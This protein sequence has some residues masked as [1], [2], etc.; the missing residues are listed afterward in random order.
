MRGFFGLV[1]LPAPGLGCGS[2]SFGFAALG[3]GGG[4][5]VIPVISDGTV[6]RVAAAS[7]TAV[8]LPAASD[9]FFT[10]TQGDSR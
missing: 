9:T 7:D 2:V 10:P 1:F 4:V 5:V 6:I 3:N 8:G